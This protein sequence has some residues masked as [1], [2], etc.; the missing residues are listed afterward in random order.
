MERGI[1]TP[2]SP[3][4]PSAPSRSFAVATPASLAGGTSST[5]RGDARL[6]LVDFRSGEAVRMH[7]EIA[8]LLNQGWRIK[9]AVPRLVEAKGTKLLVVMTP[10]SA[11]RTERN[12]A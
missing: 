3:R 7:P 11:R 6:L 2:E 8:P 4:E 1:S 10:P 9:S 12:L 5:A